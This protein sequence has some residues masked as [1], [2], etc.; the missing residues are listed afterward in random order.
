MNL[1]KVGQ[2]ALLR[3]ALIITCM[4]LADAW[5]YHNTLHP[6]RYFIAT[7]FFDMV[8]ILGLSVAHTYRFHSKPKTLAKDLS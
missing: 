8:L 5:I 2:K 1:T 3:I 7:S 4:I 6:S